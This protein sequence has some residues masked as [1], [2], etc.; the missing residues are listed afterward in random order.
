MCND[1][2]H[3]GSDCLLGGRVPSSLEACRDARPGV[4]HHLMYRS[5]AQ[6][7]RVM[8]R[9]A[10]TARRRPR[11]PTRALEPIPCP[12][13]RGAVTLRDRRAAPFHVAARQ[14]AC[15][16]RRHRCRHLRAQ[17]WLRGC[18][19]GRSPPTATAPCAMAA[20]RYSDSSCC[21]ASTARC[22]PAG[23]SPNHPAPA[24]HSATHAS[25]PARS[26]SNPTSERGL[27]G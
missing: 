10:P 15:G 11:Q 14:H 19:G 4:A 18:G 8:A 12:H 16:A 6:V 5:R 13:R 3:R 26:A 22:T 1:E 9:T 2:P 23:W 24:V 21:N 20:S 7:K 27:L 17:R 25:S